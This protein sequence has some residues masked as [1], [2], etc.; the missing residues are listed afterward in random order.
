[1]EISGYLRFKK[2]SILVKGTF[3]VDWF[4]ICEASRDLRQISW[5]SRQTKS[6]TEFVQEQDVAQEA[7]VKRLKFS[8]TD[9]EIDVLGAP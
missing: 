3:Y 2:Y 5:Y 1:M 7:V 8:W 4:Q 9:R 6:E